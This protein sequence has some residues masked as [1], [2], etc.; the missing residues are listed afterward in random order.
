MTHLSEGDMSCGPELRRRIDRL[1]TQALVVG[2]AGIALAL[3]SWVLWP[4]HFFAAY[5][6]GYLFWMGVVLGSLGLT[7]LHHLTGGSWGLVVRRPL[8][9]GAATVPLM[10]LLFVPLALG[11][12]ALYPW[13]R[14]E[15]AEHLGA[16]LR[17]L[18]YSNEPAS[19]QAAGEPVI[20]WRMDHT[21]APA[22]RVVELA[23]PNE[24]PSPERTT[25]ANERAG[26]R[27]SVCREHVRRGGL[28][29]VARGAVDVDHFRRD[30]DNR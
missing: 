30:V 16:H 26:N 23:G 7:M 28:G 10:A 1:Q 19:F 3:V 21:R 24:R 15:A 6:V 5:L 9:A 20:S 11:V 27:D 8:E 22:G 25:R 4:R 18:R 13:A 2:G 12:P 29:D 14:A 17:G